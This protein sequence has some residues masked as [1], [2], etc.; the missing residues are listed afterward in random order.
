[1]RFHGDVE[2]GQL[3]LDLAVGGTSVVRVAAGTLLLASSFCFFSSGDFVTVIH[4]QMY[5]SDTK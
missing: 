2:E 5:D 1:M 4:G 3:W